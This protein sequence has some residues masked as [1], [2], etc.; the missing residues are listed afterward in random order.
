MPPPCRRVTVSAEDQTLPYRVLV[1]IARLAVRWYYRGV[2]FDGATRIPR[3]RCSRCSVMA[4]SRV[5]RHVGILVIILIRATFIY[6]SFRV[7]RSVTIKAP[8]EKIFAL[9]NDFHNFGQWSPWEHL[10]PDMQC[11]ITDSARRKGAVYE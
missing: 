2:T 4:T 11:S 5:R 9:I 6:D 1:G 8:P 10:D 3:R 7:E